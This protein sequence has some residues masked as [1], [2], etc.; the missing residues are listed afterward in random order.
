MDSDVLIFLAVVFLRF[1]VPLLIPRFP[2]PSIIACLII[3]GVDQTI[4]QKYTDLDLTGYQG[5]D[6]AL[7]IYYLT[8]A[9]LATMRN[10]QNIHA[11]EVSRFLFYYRM[12]GVILF[13]L[14]HN[15][16]LLLIFPNTF[17]YFFIF[18]EATR[19]RWSPSRLSRKTII[20]AAAFIWIVIKLPQEYWIHVAQLDTTD[21]MKEHS[22][23]LPAMIVAIVA[24]LVGGYWALT[25]KCPPADVPL[26]FDADAGEPD[27]T[28]D[29]VAGAHRT[30]VTRFFDSELLEKIIMVSMISVIF[31]NVLPNVNSTKLQLSAGV[32]AIIIVNTLLSV[33]LAKRG[34]GWSS[35]LTQFIAMAGANIVIAFAFYL[36][37]RSGSG[38]IHLGN[39][40]F[41]LLLLTLL[42]T[43]FDRYRPFYLARVGVTGPATA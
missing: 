19:L 27:L 18:I 23:M 3:D 11:F 17:E 43:L 20:I 32:A 6:K 28:P 12:V 33:W 30:F 8:I 13:E 2:L 14:L 31:S 40:L 36:I 39:T 10:W 7:D 21:L 9:Y 25:R 42:V 41:F 26:R 4:F 38:S 37:L 15:R 29:Q 24:I 34:V 5:Y 35:A 16:T 1:S 22:W